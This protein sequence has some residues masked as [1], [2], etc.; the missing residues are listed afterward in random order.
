MKN[1]KS[2]FS[3]TSQSQSDDDIAPACNENMAQNQAVQNELSTHKENLAQNQ[4]VLD[5]LSEE[6]IHDDQ[7]I[8]QNNLSFETDDVM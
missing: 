3:R 8:V 7:T 4:A 5:E 2:L 6:D 1:N